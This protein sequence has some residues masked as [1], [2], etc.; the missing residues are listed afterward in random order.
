MGSLILWSEYVCDALRP[1]ETPEIGPH[2]RLV[3]GS[4][5]TGPPIFEFISSLL[6][7]GG[8]IGRRFDNNSDNSFG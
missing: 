4:I 1:P 7:G 2:N 5:P 8:A 6:G 3:V